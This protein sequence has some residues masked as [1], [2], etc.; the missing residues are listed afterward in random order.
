[1]GMDGGMCGGS[2]DGGWMGE[3][4]CRMNGGM[5]VGSGNGGWMGKMDVGWMG[6]WVEGV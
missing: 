5:G 2:V 1:M 3:N 6:E 4:G